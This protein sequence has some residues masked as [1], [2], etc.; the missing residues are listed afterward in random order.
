[1]AWWTEKR[2]AFYE[3]AQEASPFTSQLADL[4]E[5]CLTGSV[6][7][8]GCGLGFM[9][10]ELRRRGHA[11]TGYD[12]DPL[13]LAYARSHFPLSSFSGE[14]C[15]SLKDVA[16]TSLAVFFGRPTVDDNLT[17]LMDTCT[18]RL[19]YI[20]NEHADAA[21]CDWHISASTEAFLKDRGCRFTA[22]RCS[23]S[24][25]QPLLD[26][27][28]LAEWTQ[29]NYTRRGRTLTRPVSRRTQ[30]WPIVVECGKAFTIFIIEKKRS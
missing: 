26:E 5:P 21:Q 16:D 20:A 25:D 9:T 15:Y 14:D 30:L 11:V 3:R 19:V 7:E 10:E 24:F 6:A 13:A 23:L 4:I 1:M 12:T 22:K 2:I 27:V 29:E 28:E 18:Q 17:R 8:L